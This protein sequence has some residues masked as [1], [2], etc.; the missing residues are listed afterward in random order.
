MQMEAP[1]PWFAVAISVISAV[2]TT[3][4]A[5]YVAV[6]SRRQWQTNNDKL[7]LD[8]YD[9]RFQIYLAVLDFYK[10]LIG[11][12]G[13][14]AQVATQ[15]P[16]LQAYRESVF[17]FPAKSGVYE[18]LTEFQIHAQNITQYEGF[19][20]LFRSAGMLPTKTTERLDSQAWILKSIE[21]I[22]EKMK[23]FISFDRL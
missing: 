1:N 18:L 6:I 15:M 12:Q 23:P 5:A 14:D 8:L 3:T 22:E 2:S 20:E 7:R 21:T 4:V 16:F 11:W 19:V 17:I 13:T 9:R 10:A